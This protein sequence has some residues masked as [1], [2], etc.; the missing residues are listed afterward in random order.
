MIFNFSKFCSTVLNL[1]N[2]HFRQGYEKKGKGKG[3][4]KSGVAL[5]GTGKGKMNGIA[6]VSSCLVSLICNG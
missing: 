5:K 2:A 6:S 3:K 4:S 1:Y